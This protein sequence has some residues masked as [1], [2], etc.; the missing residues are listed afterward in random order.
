MSRALRL[1]LSAA[2]LAVGAAMVLIG[3]FHNE[4]AAVLRKAI[5]ICLECIGIG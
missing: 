2:L 5:L 3:I 1:A 4:A